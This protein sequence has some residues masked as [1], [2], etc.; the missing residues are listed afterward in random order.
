MA[1]PQGLNGK[2]Y[3]RDDADAQDGHQRMIEDCRTVRAYPRA[4]L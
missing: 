3:A 1:P 2:N 4:V